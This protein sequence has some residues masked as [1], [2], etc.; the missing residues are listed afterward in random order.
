M[1]REAPPNPPTPPGAAVVTGD[2]E[3]LARALFEAAVVRRKLDA[4]PWE[5]LE[6]SVEEAWL[7]YAR[8]GLAALTGGRPEAGG[9]D[10][11]AWAALMGQV[12][13][14]NAAIRDFLDALRESE[15]AGK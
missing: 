9:P 5:Q 10:E 11:L 7:D 12:R 3:R 2:L 4:P 15:R 14:A 8:E 13:E 6:P 1:A